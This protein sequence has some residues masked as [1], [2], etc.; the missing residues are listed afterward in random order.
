MRPCASLFT[1]FNM[2]VR[3]HKLLAMMS[4]YFPPILFCFLLLLDNKR[5]V[6]VMPLSHTSRKSRP[7]YLVER[8]L[9]VSTGNLFETA[10][11]RRHRW[12]YIRT[13]CALHRLF[14]QEGSRISANWPRIARKS[15]ISD[16]IT[17]ASC[18]TDPTSSGELK[19]W[20]LANSRKKHFHFIHSKEARKLFLLLNSVEFSAP[21]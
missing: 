6:L 18:I 15:T 14:L 19:K 4:A 3:I 1:S 8:A 16:T 21:I 2:Y 11:R 20:K 9:R 5:G 12:P 10:F 13:Q 7:T 17:T